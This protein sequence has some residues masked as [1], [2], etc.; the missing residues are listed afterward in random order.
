MINF[1]TLGKPFHVWQII[2]ENK[3]FK[4]SMQK[5]T[6]FEDVLPILNKFGEYS[7]EQLAYLKSEIES[8]LHR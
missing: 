8:R 5:A 7:D 6:C 1:K 3:E 4:T 2:R